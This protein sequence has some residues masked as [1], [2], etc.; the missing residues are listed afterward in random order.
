MSKSIL[1]I[2][3]QHAHPKYN[4]ERADWLGKFIAER[5]PN[6]VVNIGDGAD[7]P[8]LSSFDKGKASFHGQS[9]EADINSHVDFQ[10]RVW[11]TVRKAKKKRPDTYYFIGN[12]E[13]RIQKVLEYE[14]HLAGD[15][16]GVSFKDYALNDYYSEVITYDGSTPG[17]RQIEGITFA[18]F[19]PSGAMGRPIEGEH[20][21]ASLIAK[22]HTSCVVGHSHK[23]DY[24][25]RADVNGKQ[26]HSLV[27]GVYQDYTNPWVGVTGNMWW[28][29]IVMLQGVEDGHFEP[30]FISLNRLKVGYS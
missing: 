22:H 29:G 5:K 2:P 9:Y 12:H 28:R 20:H 27:C 16:Y 25:V 7:M 10:D 13:Q 8:S 19:L 17:T 15:R 30:E 11:H 24:A 1:V 21:A 14:P 23:V 3:D 6:I 26:F 4:N 18:H